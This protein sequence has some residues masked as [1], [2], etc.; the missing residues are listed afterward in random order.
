M[1]DWSC[2]WGL[3]PLGCVSMYI[4]V[5]NFLLSRKRRLK[6]R[7]GLLFLPVFVLP[8]LTFYEKGNVNVMCFTTGY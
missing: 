6:K 3:T 4:Q 8:L 1:A 7:S 5:L 2:N